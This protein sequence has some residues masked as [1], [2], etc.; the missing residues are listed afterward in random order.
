MRESASCTHPAQLACGNPRT[1]RGLGGVGKGARWAGK[2]TRRGAPRP[3]RHSA[4]DRRGSRRL[5]SRAYTA[6][7]RIVATS[8]LNYTAAFEH[9]AP[10]KREV[11]G[12]CCVGEVQL[13]V[14]GGAFLLRLVIAAAACRRHHRVPCLLA[15]CLT[16]R[17]EGLE[18]TS[19]PCGC[20]L[21]ALCSVCNVRDT[22]TAGGPVFCA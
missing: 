9:V 13:L 22:H 14:A 20:V 4:A 21:E 1:R 10:R 3:A 18:V 7:E 8:T 15:R 2:L 16:W 11:R 6:Q 17:G 5:S 19:R 12:Y